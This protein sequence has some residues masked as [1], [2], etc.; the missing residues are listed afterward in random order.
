MGADSFYSSVLPEQGLRVLAVF[1][2]GLKRPPTHLY[3]D[4]NE[5]LLAAAET[6]SKL[7]KNVYHGCASYLTP[8]TRKAENAAAA[9]ALWVD[10]DVGPTKPYKTQRDAAA[11]LA[12]MCD[13]VGLSK[14]YFVSSGSGVHAYFP[15]TKSITPEQWKKLASVFAT[16]LDH[17]GVKHDT[18]R[19]EDLA[20]VLRIPGTSNYKTEPPKLVR[21]VQSGIA[22]PAADLYKKLK[23]YAE[24][25][26]ILLTDKAAKTAAT[27]DLIGNP[28][29]PPSEGQEIA[30]HCAIIGHVD[31]TGGDEGYEVWWRT[32]GIAKHTVNPEQTAAHWTRNR[33]ATGHEKADYI[34]L[35]SE[36]TVGPTT[37]EEFSRHSTKCQTCPQFGKIKSPIQLGQ[38]ELPVVEPLPQAPV[39][40]PKEEWTFGAQWI[41]DQIAKRSR[42]GFFD[43]RL[44]MSEQQ[45]DG[46]YKHKPICDRYWQ[47]MGR[48]RAPDDTWK[49]EI[50]YA[51]YPGQDHKTFLMDSAAVTSPDML[52]KEFSARELHIY[53][54]P[55]AMQAAQRKIMDEQ[56]ILFGSGVET[57]TVPLMGWETYNFTPR[58]E[59][60][61]NFVIGDDLIVPNAPPKKIRLDDSIYEPFR[62]DMKTKGTTGEWVALVDRIY[63]RAGAEPYQF[64]IAAMFAAPLVKLVPNENTWHGI[65]IALTGESGAAKTSTAQVAMSIYAP[66]SVLVFNANSNK[67]GQGDTTNAF[68][69]KVGM[70]QNI[71]FVADEMT[72][73]DP[74]KMASIMYMLANGKSKDRLGPTGKLIENKARWDT[75][76][77]ATGNDIFH[78][79]LRLLT[80]HATQEATQIRCFQIHLRKEDIATVFYD[81]HKTTVEHDL[82]ASQY[83]CVGRDWLQF[84]VNKRL[85]I[86]ELLGKAR[87]TYKVTDDD[88]TSI[89][90]YKDLLLTVEIAAQLAKKEGFI[91]WDIDVMMRW[92]KANME[93]LVGGVFEK[94]WDSTVSDFIASLHG[95]TIVTKLFRPG[96]GRPTGYPEVPLE[97]L[98]S[99]ALPV[100]RRAVDDRQFW[101]TGAYLKEW[102]KSRSLSES[103]L[104]SELTTSGMLDASGG[105]TAKSVSLGAGSTVVRTA[106]P[107]W[108]LDYDKAMSIVTAPPASGNVVTLPV[109]QSVTPPAAAASATP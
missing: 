109:T 80:N 96:P 71:P 44:T 99:T 82:L 19:T 22:T 33:L 36:W 13:T 43:G 86:E 69:A 2:D 85:K 60:T 64:I 87:R 4:D 76:S 70:L 73:V 97:P 94:D 48:V 15:L 53:G 81:V 54:G 25:N 100:A 101:V 88:T 41:R 84:V 106:C 42:V 21:I 66:A 57:V 49:L 108:Q 77:I 91:H 105:L 93:K 90:F 16:V 62:Y 102:A 52:R 10:L 27:N 3:F 72:G 74:E 79:K 98:S 1:K 31:S 23:E 56:D 47:V 11:A 61:G 6:W 50:G 39:A 30:K 103:A 17:A 92:A 7:G 107:C 65:P 51:T 63:N 45:D 40:P 104:I 59:L 58:G 18:S 78:E 32:I 89:R 14:P 24:S 9:K 20:S 75:I 12:T 55:R 5:D 68:A 29:Y 26:S 95:K 46:T 28:N 37:C 38:P 83:G 35:M 8:E 67:D 34:R